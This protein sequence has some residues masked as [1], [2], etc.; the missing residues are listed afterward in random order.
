MPLSY[1]VERMKLRKDKTALMVNDSLT[2][3]GI[4]SDVFEYRLGNRSVLEW[5]IDQYRVKTDN[6]S[7]IRSDPKR[8]DDE[9]YIV[10]PSSAS[11]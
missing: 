2:L 1:H 11:A 7:G 8:P 6:R 3:A 10:R 5:I 4:P 9:E